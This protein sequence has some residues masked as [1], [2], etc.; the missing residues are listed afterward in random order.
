MD[1]AYVQHQIL[2]AEAFYTLMFSAFWLNVSV[3]VLIRIW[4][5]AYQREMDGG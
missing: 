4:R 1:I 5:P 3:P 2:N